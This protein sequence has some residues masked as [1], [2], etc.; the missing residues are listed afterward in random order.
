MMKNTATAACAVDR[1]GTSRI[2]TTKSAKSVTNGYVKKRIDVRRSERKP[3]HAAYVVSLLCN[4]KC[5]LA[6]AV[7]R[8]RQDNRGNGRRCERRRAGD[9]FAQHGFRGWR[10][11][12]LYAGSAWTGGFLACLVGWRGGYTLAGWTAKGN[13]DGG[14]S[15][16]PDCRDR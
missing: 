7:R 9:R 3:H 6:E 2:C 8:G 1:Y 16:Q 14:L 4:K 5:S 10:R 15:L 13:H 12:D 11:G